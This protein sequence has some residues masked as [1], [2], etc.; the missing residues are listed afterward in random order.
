MAYL[1]HLVGGLWWKCQEKGFSWMVEVQTES[2]KDLEQTL[3]R[4]YNFAAIEN[5]PEGVAEAWGRERGWGCGHT[6]VQTGK[7][8]LTEGSRDRRA[9][10]NKASHSHQLQ[11]DRSHCWLRTELTSQQSLQMSQIA[12]DPH[13]LISPTGSTQ[14]VA[15]DSGGSPVWRINTY[16]KIGL[17]AVVKCREGIEYTVPWEKKMGWA[18]V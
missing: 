18:S 15:T 5:L 1:G 17:Q 7:A 13:A 16:W 14:W 8:W 6:P 3:L 9:R 11:G 12:M 2:R 4:N 10:Q